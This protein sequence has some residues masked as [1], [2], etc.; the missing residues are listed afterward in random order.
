MKT[1]WVRILFFLV[2][3]PILFVGIFYYME[4][5]GAFLIDAIDVRLAEGTPHSHFLV[6]LVSDLN[7]EFRDLKGTP[8]WDIELKSVLAIATRHPW[9]E[10][11]SIHR[12]WPSL[13]V[14][15]LTVREVYALLLDTRGNLIPVLGDGSLLPAVQSSVRAPD[16]PLMRE[17]EFH[18]SLELRK[19]AAELLKEIPI[20]GKGLTRK[21]ISEI[22]YS[23]REGFSIL[24]TEG[25]ALVTLGQEKF[26][27]KAQRVSQVMEYIQSRGIEAR[28][29][30]ANLSKKVLVRPRKDP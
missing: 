11:I 23:S 10:N 21:S 22:K 29:I 16:V 15:N 18:T 5:R 13:L 4:R 28:V 8:L 14:V 1:N 20:S 3:L 30:D 12:A 2:A 26:A 25:E 7:S 9:V 27:Q 24:L 6:P 17:K 19:K